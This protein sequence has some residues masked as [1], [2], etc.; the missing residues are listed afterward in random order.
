MHNEPY[1]FSK[2]ALFLLSDTDVICDVSNDDKLIVTYQIQTGTT[3]ILSLLVFFMQL[4]VTYLNHQNILYF[5]LLFR[6]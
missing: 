1:D 3:T 5:M 6:I 2:T 4:H